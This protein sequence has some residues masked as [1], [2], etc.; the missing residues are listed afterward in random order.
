MQQY[1]VASDVRPVAS[2]G[3]G[4]GLGPLPAIQISNRPGHRAAPAERPSIRH[5]PLP[6]VR[7]TA[8]RTIEEFPAGSMLPYTSEVA[9]AANTYFTRGEAVGLAPGTRAVEALACIANAPESSSG[10]NMAPRRIAK[11][12]HDLGLR[13]RQCHR[14]Y[15]SVADKRARIETIARDVSLTSNGCRSRIDP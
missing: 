8:W 2:T 10:L 14:R 5:H 3:S 12:N 11:R 6:L 7:S 1:G 9:P 15:C 4:R 13:K